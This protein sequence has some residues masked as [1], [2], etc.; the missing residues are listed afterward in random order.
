MTYTTHADLGGQTG[1]GAV[2]PEAEGEI[3]R[4]SWEP[5]ALALSLA[6]GA[7]G[8]WNIDI[9]RSARETL[10]NYAELSYYEIWTLALQKLLEQRHLA[11][12]DEISAG[13]KLRE[14]PAVER[15]LLADDVPGVLASGS[16]T[17][18]TVAGSPRFTAGQRVR[19]RSGRVDHHT[20]LPGYVSGRTGVVERNHGAHV[21]ADAHAH[22]LGEQ[23]QYLYTVAFEGAEL[24]GDESRGLTVSIDAWE[25]YLEPA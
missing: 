23:P 3:F 17:A 16:A 9:S 25:P 24:W 21:F 20:R 13:H 18:R 19:A 15:V 14:G 22:G 8:S 11:D 7:T 6:M 12:A 5:R 10:A 1:N 2:I 4:A